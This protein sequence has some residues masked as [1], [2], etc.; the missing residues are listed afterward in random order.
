MGKTILSEP[1]AKSQM[2]DPSRFLSYLPEPIE[3]T[4]A[5]QV[6]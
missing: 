3:I 1:A 5:E 2:I 6:N 4:D